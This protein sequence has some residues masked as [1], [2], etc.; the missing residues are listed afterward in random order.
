MVP[1]NS[2]DDLKTVSSRSES[3][4]F[5]V[6]LVIENKA[7]ETEM[8]NM[9]KIFLDVITEEKVVL[10]ER[11]LNKYRMVIRKKSKFI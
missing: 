3:M 4:T 9:A 10:I 5:I 2:A 11:I 1:N 7:I 6:L 8:I